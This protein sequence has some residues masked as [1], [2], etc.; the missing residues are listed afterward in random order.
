ELGDVLFVCANIAR[1]LDVDPE[2]TLRAANVKFTRRFQF[3]EER[4]RAAGRSPAASTLQ[5]METLWL[6]A[7]RSE[8]TPAG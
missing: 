1:E 5:E 7:K 4:L 6:A 8:A 2:E 3:I